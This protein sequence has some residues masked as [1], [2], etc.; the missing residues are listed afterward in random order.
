[1]SKKTITICSCDICGGRDA[2]S[3]RTLAYRTFDGN[4]GRNRY[5]EPVLEAVDVDLCDACAR[6]A[7]NLHDVGVCCSKFMI[8]PCP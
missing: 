5:K 1:M 7:T 8:A 6:K 2:K 4:D 3:Y